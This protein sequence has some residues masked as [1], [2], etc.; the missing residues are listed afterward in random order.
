[1]NY[2]LGVQDFDIKEANLKTR[3]DIFYMNNLFKKLNDNKMK[4]I[5]DKYNKIY[6][7]ITYLP[8]FIKNYED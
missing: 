7:S 1:L 3:I 5:Y 2:P 4:Y 8:F 6:E